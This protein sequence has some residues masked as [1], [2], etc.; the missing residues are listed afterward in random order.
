ML[1]DNS[2]H[3]WFFGCVTRELLFVFGVT[4]ELLFFEVSESV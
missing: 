4:R 2:F 3:H 1:S